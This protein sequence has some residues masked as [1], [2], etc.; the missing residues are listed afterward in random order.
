[1]TDIYLDTA[2][3]DEIEEIWQWGIIRGITTNQKIFLKEKGCDF[4][5]RAIEI[6]KMVKPYPVSIEGPN[7]PSDLIAEATKYQYWGDNVVVKVP[8][9]V[10]GD[11]IVANNALLK[12]GIKTNVTACITLNQVFLAAC[13]GATYVSLFYNRMKDY[14]KELEEVFQKEGETTCISPTDYALN[15]IKE[16]VKLLEN[17]DTRLIIGSIREPEDIEEI[18]SVKPDIIT[19]P[20]KILKQMPYNEKTKET[21]EEFEKAWEKFNE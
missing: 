17:Y 4:E 13:S 19:I 7:D 15:T 21:L 9:L 20:Y 16:S 5:D 18:L 10:D 14:W 8:M 12:H 1:M 6:L 3:L 2:N 11:G